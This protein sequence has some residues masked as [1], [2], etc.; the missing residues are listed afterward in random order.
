MDD[1]E[2]VAAALAERRRARIEGDRVRAARAARV[3]AERERVRVYPP[4]V[5]LTAAELDKETGR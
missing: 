1:E 2:R 3:A 5:G 4:A